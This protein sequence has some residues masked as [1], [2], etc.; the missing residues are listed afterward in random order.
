MACRTRT[1]DRRRDAWLIFHPENSELG[2]RDPRF[3]R[4]G[5]EP[6]A[7]IDPGFVDPFRIDPTSVRCPRAL[8]KSHGIRVAAGQHT[9][10]VVCTG[11]AD[12]KAT[13]IYATAYGRDASF[14]AFT[15]SLETYERTMDPNTVFILGT[16]SEFLRFLE[17]PR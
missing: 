2:R 14:Y 10:F 5:H 6:V 3:P 16:D 11:E 12:A 13:A 17:T 7:H 4:Q 1:D 9:L 15:K 8:R